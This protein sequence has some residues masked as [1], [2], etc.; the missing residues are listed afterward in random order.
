MAFVKDKDF[1][2]QKMRADKLR[3]Y[4]VFDSDNK[5][6]IDEN[7]DNEVS[8]EEAA[9]ALANTM[10]NVSGLFYIVLSEVNNKTKGEGGVQ[11]AKKNL[12][13]TIKIGDE[14]NRT[15]SGPAQSPGFNLEQIQSSLK[16]EMELRMQLLEMQYKHKAEIEALK[17]QEE[18]PNPYVI[19][20]L[21][22]LQGIMGAQPSA[23]MAPIAGPEV[24]HVQRLNGAVKRLLV[25]DPNFT[26]HIEKLA[27]IAENNPSL[28]NMAISFLNK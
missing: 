3:F 1:I 6:K 10:D 12:K 21:K 19:E 15:I 27:D 11:T 26:D 28:Y 24:T 7:Q 13:F 4:T 23:S 20:G 8:L 22:M 18:A 5:T 9:Q 25:A 17:N 16:T 14:P 2:L